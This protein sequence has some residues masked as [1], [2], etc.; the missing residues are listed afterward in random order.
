MSPT[1]PEPE[2]EYSRAG[3]TSDRDSASARG[4]WKR[5]PSRLATAVAAGGG[6]G[7]ALLV[8]AEF[9]PLLIVHSSANNRVIETV[10]SGS[11][12][13][14][15]LIPIAVLAGLMSWVAWRTQSRLAM[16][17][18]GA[19]GGVTLLIALLGDLPNAQASGL[20]GSPASGFALASSSP[21]TGLYFET[22]G[23]IVLLASAGAG[24]LAL[25][26]SDRAD[27][28]TDRPTR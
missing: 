4:L 27:D 21:S 2:T 15:A 9:T 16:A 10:T 24:L 23:A 5:P 8:V 11:N 12:H 20:I 18:R 7:A 26:G 1:R 14:Y 13:S 19:L 22:L 3:G 28:A 6:L 25:G 17:A